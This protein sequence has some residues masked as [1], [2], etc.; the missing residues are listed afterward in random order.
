MK[1]LISIVIPCYNEEA[2]IIETYKRLTSVMACTEKR[3]NYELIFAND[4]SKD[5]TLKLLKEISRNDSHVKI[6]NFSRNFG[7]QIAVT[8]GIDSAKGDAVVLIDADLQDPPELI[9]EFIEQWENGYEVVYA[10]RR[11]RIGETWFK[12]VTAS[13]F[14]RYLHKI[15]DIN[16]PVDTGDFRLMSR[17]VVNVLKQIKERHRFIRGLVSWVGFKQIGIPYDRAERFAGETKYPLKKMIKFSIDAITSFSYFPLKIAG[18]LGVSSAIL[19]VF[20]IIISLIL[21]FTTD[22]VIQGWT[23]LMI[24]MLFLGGMQLFILG[25]IGEY[26]G[27][28]YDE[29][30]NRPLYIVDDE[31]IQSNMNEPQDDKVKHISARM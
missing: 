30:R 22:Y 21:K 25:I 9:L 6:I 1:K 3:Y 10:V 5:M 8:A 27:R 23:S 20:G 11:K 28:I 16:I 2:V 19:G 15:T 31:D 24:V 17:K 4:G 18:F 26:L 14:Y 7:H 13:Y 12:K 29:T